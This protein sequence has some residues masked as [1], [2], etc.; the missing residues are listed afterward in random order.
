M[1]DRRRSGA[2]C[3]RHQ[4]GDIEP[5]DPSKRRTLDSGSQQKK[6]HGIVKVA[7]GNTQTH[8]TLV[9]DHKCRGHLR[10]ESKNSFTSSL[11][12]ADVQDITTIG[13]PA[14]P[15]G[16]SRPS[17]RHS[18]E[19]GVQPEFRGRGGLSS[20]DMSAW[21]PGSSCCSPVVSRCR[22]P[23]VSSAYRK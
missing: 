1:C 17:S 13:Y 15:A 5:V 11:L 6:K 14:K 22:L 12:S 16:I 9:K 21:N 19:A 4:Q 18:S 23:E 8:F 2:E 20:P 7:A 3:L 10:S